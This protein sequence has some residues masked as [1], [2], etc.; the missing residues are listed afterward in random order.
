[1]QSMMMKSTFILLWCN[2]WQRWRYVHLRCSSRWRRF[3]QTSRQNLQTCSFQISFLFLHSQ[4]R[5]ALHLQ[6]TNTQRINHLRRHTRELQSLI[7]T[8]EWYFSTYQ[9]E[10]CCGWWTIQFWPRGDLVHCWEDASLESLQKST[11][12]GK[13]VTKGE[14]R[15]EEM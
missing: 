10:C 4:R 1:M 9:A 6:M 13:R 7:C 3:P 8:Q 2:K 15:G 11:D 12:N 14:R 5:K